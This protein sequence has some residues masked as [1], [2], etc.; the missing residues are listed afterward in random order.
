MSSHKP[1][2][3]KNNMSTHLRVSYISYY[4]MP[5]SFFLYIQCTTK[6][7]YSFDVEG[8]GEEEKNEDTKR[9]IMIRSHK[10]KTG[11]TIQW[12]KVKGQKNNNDL[13]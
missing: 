1:S 11:L 7:C 8:G 5:I 13:Q 9:V 3:P 4:T 6:P 12:P 2:G 10:S